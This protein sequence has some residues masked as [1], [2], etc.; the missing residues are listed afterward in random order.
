MIC[1]DS[2]VTPVPE[3]GKEP[4]E[5]PRQRSDELL[6][7][8]VELRGLDDL[9]PDRLPRPLL[10]E[11]LVGAVKDRAVHVPLLQKLVDIQDGIGPLRLSV[12]LLKNLQMGFDRITHE[13]LIEITAVA[14]ILARVR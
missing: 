9:F 7:T 11:D 8:A 13:G 6:R 12:D 2:P 1:K 14:V 5:Y 3:V 10:V 4:V